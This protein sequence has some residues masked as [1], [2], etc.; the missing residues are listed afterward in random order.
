M[1]VYDFGWQLGTKG[2][3]KAGEGRLRLQMHATDPDMLERRMGTSRSKGRIRIPAAWMFFSISMRFSMPTTTQRSLRE[4]V[5][6]SHEKPDADA[7]VRRYLE[8]V[9]T[10]PD[11]RPDW[12]NPEG[13]PGAS[14]AAVR[15]S[16][17]QSGARGLTQAAR[18][19]GT[20]PAAVRVRVG[21]P[22]DMTAARGA[23][24][25]ICRCAG[26]SPATM[27]PTMKSNLPNMASLRRRPQCRWR[28]SLEPFRLYKKRTSLRVQQQNIARNDPGQV[29]QGSRSISAGSPIPVRL[30]RCLS[31]CNPS[32]LQGAVEGGAAN[33]TGPS[34][35]DSPSQFRP[36]DPT[37]PT[38]TSQAG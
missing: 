33:S 36:A 15:K 12:P 2:W 31:R 14:R 28:A 35:G 7:L 18:R 10:G 9:D 23:N 3:G 30:R 11:A 27:Q 1:R 19:A 24:A 17:R 8:I 26:T 38:S 5:P 21:V 25:M 37:A 29:V 13:S 20:A 6:T 34:A 22:C 16:M 4:N 32:A